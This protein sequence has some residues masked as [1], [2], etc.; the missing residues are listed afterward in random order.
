MRCSQ[1][2]IPGVLLRRPPPQRQSQVRCLEKTATT[3]RSVYLL[4]PFPTVASGTGRDGL[5]SL[6]PFGSR[7]GWLMSL[8]AFAFYFCFFFLG[9]E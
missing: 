4:L 8:L 1:S 3:C 6:V 5:R 9:P 2:S 7:K